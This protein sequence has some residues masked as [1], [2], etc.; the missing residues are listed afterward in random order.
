MKITI[1][2][3]WILAI[4]LVLI[5]G[6]VAPMLVSSSDTTLSAAGFLLVGIFLTVIFL[7]G[8]RKCIKQ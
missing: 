8:K 5:I 1:L 6:T 3:V 4:S 2:E 7:W